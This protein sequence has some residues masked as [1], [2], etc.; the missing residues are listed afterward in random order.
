M[1]AQV[2]LI[3]P[4]EVIVSLPNQLLGHIPITNITAEYTA[5]L[6]ALHQDESDSEYEGTSSETGDE[7]IPGLEDLFIVG[8]WLNCIV[9]E[10]KALTGNSI[11]GGRE[12]DEN[13]RASRKIEL[14]TEP[15][16]LNE[17]IAKADLTTGFVRGV[18]TNVDTSKLI[19]QFRRLSVHL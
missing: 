12:G 4:L 10:S 14:S 17:G 3:R 18:R 8:Q 1:L 13:V 11:V 6:E 5:R 16:K 9:V 2:I 15:E 19:I 7:R